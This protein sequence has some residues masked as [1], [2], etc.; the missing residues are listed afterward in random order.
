MLTNLDFAQDKQKKEEEVSYT[1][2]LQSPN[3]ITKHYTFPP[4][5]RHRLLRWCSAPARARRPAPAQT[6]DGARG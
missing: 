3:V 2:T 6:A 5:V 4:C 1:Y